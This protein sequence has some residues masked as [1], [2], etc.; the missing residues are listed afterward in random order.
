MLF[1]KKQCV[2]P[3][4][5]RWQ[6]LLNQNT[7]KVRLCFFFCEICGIDQFIWTSIASLEEIPKDEALTLKRLRT[8]PRSMLSS[9]YRCSAYSS[10]LITSNMI[11]K[12]LSWLT[13]SKAPL[14]STRAKYNGRLA[15]AWVV[16]LELQWPTLFHAHSLE[17]SQFGVHIRRRKQRIPNMRW[18]ASLSQ[19]WCITL[20]TF[21]KFRI[22][23]MGLRIELIEG[24]RYFCDFDGRDPSGSWYQRVFSQRKYNFI[25]SSSKVGDTS[26]ARLLR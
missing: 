1:K 20:D 2:I 11:S 23:N 10:P 13:V 16:Q 14:I 19:N 12:S 22:L 6:N 21:S 7:M 24:P 9:Q 17:I 5:E 25:C 18:F 4:H 26:H 3:F 8:F 15:L